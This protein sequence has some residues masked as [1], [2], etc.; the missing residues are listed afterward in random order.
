MRCAGHLTAEQVEMYEEL[1]NAPA[2]A[3]LI[4]Q[5]AR[6][7]EYEELGRYFAP[8]P[9]RRLILRSRQN[10]RG[11]RRRS[12]ARRLARAN[13]P[14]DDSEGE[15]EPGRARHLTRTEGGS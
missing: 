11:G 15:H 3:E 8:A 5:A 4:E 9:L 1:A 13:S 6:D 14:P 10:C 2:H 12:H 7:R